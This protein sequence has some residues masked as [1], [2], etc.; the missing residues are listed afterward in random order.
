M[1]S[2]HFVAAIRIWFCGGEI[3][4]PPQ[5]T[6]IVVRVPKICVAGL[7]ATE[8]VPGPASLV[9]RVGEHEVVIRREMLGRIVPRVYLLP[10][11][12]AY[13]VRAAE[14]LIHQYLAVV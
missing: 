14:Y 10:H 3:R 6:F 12:G 13:E 1:G 7:G 4:S 5:S 8:L 11:N 2:S 9:L